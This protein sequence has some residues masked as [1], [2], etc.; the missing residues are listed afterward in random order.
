MASAVVPTP[1]GKN[2][3][4]VSVNIFSDIVLSFPSLRYVSRKSRVL[5]AS[6]EALWS[7]ISLEISF[8]K[9]SDLSKD[10][11]N[12]TCW[13]KLVNKTEFLRQGEGI[14]ELFG[15]LYKFVQVITTPGIPFVQKN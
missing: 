3:E 14:D 9:P 13:N 2:M 1:S 11:F 8:L 15:N 5:F 7:L 4:M 6:K 10:N 12:E